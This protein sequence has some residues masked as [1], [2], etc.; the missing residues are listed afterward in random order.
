MLLRI[1]VPYFLVA[2]ILL[3]VCLLTILAV[4]VFYIYAGD[5][6]QLVA[7][8]KI[9]ALVLFS[10]LPGSIFYLVT[11]IFALWAASINTFLGIP[12]DLEN[13]TLGVEGSEGGTWLIF[14]QIALLLSLITAIILKQFSYRSIDLKYY[15]QQDHLINKGSEILRVE[16]LKVHYPI[17]GGFLKRTIGYV[18]AVN[19]VSFSIKSGETLGLVGESGC[20]KSTIAKAILGLVDKNEGQILFDGEEL[21][22]PLPN[23]L[24]QQIQIVFQDP[25]ASLNPR[26]KIVDIVGEPLR[27]LMG[28]TNKDEIRGIVLQIL[29]KVSL[30]R[31]HL[32][33]HPH[34]FSGG[35]KQ[36]ITIARA[37]AC[38]PRL[39][40][41]DEPTS[42]LDVSV[43]AG[44][45][46][47]LKELQQEFGYGFLFITHNLSV[48]NHIADNV[49]VMYLGRFVEY[50]PVDEIF[51]N[52]VHPYTQALL[53]A[54]SDI[55]FDHQI[56]RIILQ[57]EVPSPVNPPPGCSFN[58][59]C[60]FK[61]CSEK[62]NEIPP[63]AFKYGEKHVVWCYKLEGE[64]IEVE[65]NYTIQNREVR[66]L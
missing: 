13:F 50:G 41:L 42:A 22:L 11:S 16:R 65:D 53:S 55:D 64:C 21:T 44:I 54:R 12:I 51:H 45:L 58:P 43:Q 14:I 39:I 36:R 6:I 5:R 2:L 66:D 3:V 30:K 33:R 49:A 37:L 57:G 59:R 15:Q 32:D 23:H 62:C 27:N 35:Q 60:N 10:I 40:I 63:K 1:D 7:E 9:K 56:D 20:G 28:I 31:E 29:K 17:I 34:E 61:T 46:N 52:P 19:G 38:N 48:V 47:L 18:K 24:R 26:M 4:I 8:R 25:D